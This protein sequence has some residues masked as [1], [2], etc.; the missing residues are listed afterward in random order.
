MELICDSINRTGNYNNEDINR[1]VRQ[2]LGKSVDR[3]IEQ[4]WQEL[5]DDWNKRHQKAAQAVV[6]IVRKAK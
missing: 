1:Q 5:D 6:A 2:R 3:E 4:I